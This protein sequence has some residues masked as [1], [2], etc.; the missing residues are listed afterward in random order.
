MQ[1][2]K[3]RWPG[4]FLI[5]LRGSFL[6]IL[7]SI[8]L[9]SVAR[10]VLMRRASFWCIQINLPLYCP[11]PQPIKLT[12]RKKPKSCLSNLTLP[13]TASLLTW[14]YSA[15]QQQEATNA[16]ATFLTLSLVLAVVTMLTGWF[17]VSAISK[18]LSCLTIAVSE[19]AKN[20]DL[21]VKAKVLAQDELGKTASHLNQMFD[22]FSGAIDE[23]GK[24]SVQLASAAEETATTVEV[25]TGR[26]AIISS[27]NQMS[28][29]AFEAIQEST[30]LANQTASQTG[31]LEGALENIHA[32]VMAI[33]D[34]AT[35]AEITRN[36][37][38]INQMTLETVSGAEQIKVVANE[39]ARMAANLQTISTAFVTT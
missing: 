37:E 11:L 4:Y 18:Q 2:A 39:Q 1:D 17:L 27:F 30:E 7:G 5:G 6:V 21:T 25:S 15:R 14:Y 29:R 3:N 20:K 16:F 13:R 8:V 24:A 9:R 34:M 28:Q 19:S 32:E 10:E 35:T 23:I 38:T 33:S 36:I 26:E 31:G 12:K 22:V